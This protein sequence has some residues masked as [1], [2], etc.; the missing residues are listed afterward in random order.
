MTA[1]IEQQTIG[2]PLDFCS[3]CG[4]L[5]EKQYQGFCVS[6]YNKNRYDTELWWKRK[7][8]NCFNL[9]AKEYWQLFEDQNGICAICG[10]SPEENGQKLSVDHDHSCCDGRKSCGM[11]VRGLL[12]SQCN[13]AIGLLG[14]DMLLKASEYLRSS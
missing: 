9:S 6:C 7:I 12:C 14:D 11:C 2:E 10:K 13:R 3:T 8:K 4:K 5:R 1:P